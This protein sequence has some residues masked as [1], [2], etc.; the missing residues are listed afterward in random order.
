MSSREEVQSVRKAVR[1]LDLL[2]TAA[3]L[4]PADVAARLGIARPTVYRLLGTLEAEGA[5]ERHDGLYSP[6][7]SLLRWAGA[8]LSRHP[9][10]TLARPFL[11]E[12]RD[13]TGETA[14]LF[15]RQGAQRVCID[16]ADSPQ[17]LRRFIEVGMTMPLHAGSAG[18]VLLSGLPDE[19]VAAL[20]ARG[21]PAL[22]G[23][24]IV[25]PEEMLAELARIRAEGVAVSLAEREEGLASISAPVFGMDGQMKAAIGVSGPLFRFTEENVKVW[26]D[27]VRHTGI[28]LSER[29]GRRAAELPAA[30]ATAGGMAQ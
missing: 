25:R 4:S 11:E 9:L 23:R 22:T 19:E 8:Y 13:R 12:L 21:M 27:E 17:A 3:P 28:R 7:P 15:V 26:R 20:L 18:K 6:G 29:L 2:A 10:V 16:K 1:I 24:T 30:T 14:C 5:V